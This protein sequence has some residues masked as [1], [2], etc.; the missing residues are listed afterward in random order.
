MKA[1][2]HAMGARPAG[3]KGKDGIVVVTMD[4]KTLTRERWSPELEC[5]HDC[6]KL[7]QIDVMAV[8]L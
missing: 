8:A 3:A 1:E 5:Y 7:K 2:L 6:K 4:D